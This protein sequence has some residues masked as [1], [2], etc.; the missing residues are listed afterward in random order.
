[1][2]LGS[3]AAKFAASVNVPLHHLATLPNNL[4]TASE[5]PLC[6]S[7]IPF[8]DVAAFATTLRG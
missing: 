1:L 3:P 5:C 7:G 4:W 2:V 6:G 8:E